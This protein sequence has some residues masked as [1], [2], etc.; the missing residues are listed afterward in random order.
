M[1]SFC[2]GLDWIRKCQPAESLTI[3]ECEW[4]GFS[5]A[6]DRLWLLN[7]HTL[8][9]YFPVNWNNEIQCVWLSAHLYVIHSMSPFCTNDKSHCKQKPSYQKTSDL[10][11]LLRED[12]NIL[13]TQTETAMAS[14]TGNWNTNLY[15]CL[16]F[17]V[18]ICWRH[19]DMTQITEFRHLG[20]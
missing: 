9:A 12:T 10:H 8:T 16:W 4:E 14:S 5:K 2:T 17:C 20:H 1:C 13:S 11:L 7:G 3:T 6:L 15:L 18:I 19:E